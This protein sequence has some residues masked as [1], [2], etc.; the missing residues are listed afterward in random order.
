MSMRK[1]CVTPGKISELVGSPKFMFKILGWNKI[2]LFKI[3]VGELLLYKSV[4][5]VMITIIASNSLVF[6]KGSGSAK[7]IFHGLFF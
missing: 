1:T 3:I 4:Y 2:L 6:S 5:W 7:Y